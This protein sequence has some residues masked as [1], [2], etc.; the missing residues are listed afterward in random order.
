[1]V[2]P[3]EPKCQMA[4]RRRRSSFESEVDLLKV[5]EQVPQRLEELV[6]LEEAVVQAVPLFSHKVSELEF[7]FVFPSL[8]T[9]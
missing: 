2:K 6:L 3:L 7:Y 8:Q 9:Y 5:H 1:M 4:A